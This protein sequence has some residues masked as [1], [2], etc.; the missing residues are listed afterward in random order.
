MTAPLQGDL[1]VPRWT[2]QEDAALAAG[3]RAGETAG[4]IAE[5]RLPARTVIAIRERLRVLGLTQKMQFATPSGEQGYLPQPPRST[6]QT[7]EGIGSRDLLR[8]LLRFGT[9]KP[10]PKGLPGLT[11]QQFLDLCRDHDVRPAFNTKEKARD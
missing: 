10:Q 4:Q 2:A 6:A 7:P 1:K 9:N 3:K 5:G 11:E 8:A